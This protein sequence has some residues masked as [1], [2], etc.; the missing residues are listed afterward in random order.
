MSRMPICPL[1]SARITARSGGRPVEELGQRLCGKPIVL[2][3]EHLL[4]LGRENNDGTLRF[5]KA[6]VDLPE[7]GLFFPVPA[8]PRKKCDE[9]AAFQ[10]FAHRAALFVGER[11]LR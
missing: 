1:S 7:R 10:D 2:Q 3:V 4:A 11:S 5:Q 9:G 8:E 6:A